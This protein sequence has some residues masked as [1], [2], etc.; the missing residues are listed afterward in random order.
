MTVDPSELR[1]WRPVIMGRQGAVVS[2]HPLATQAG[3]DVLRAG[4]NA[5]DAA[6]AVGTTLAVVEPFMSGAG[7]DGFFLVWEAGPR[8]T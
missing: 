5:A 4:G 7:G 6:V 2:N 3:F 8:R 1:T